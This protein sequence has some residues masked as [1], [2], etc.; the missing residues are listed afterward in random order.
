VAKG[1]KVLKYG[2]AGGVTTLYVAAVVHAQ[3]YPDLPKADWRRVA[4]VAG[5]LTGLTWV[6]TVV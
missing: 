5:L 3:R 2:A 4:I 1:R 6:A